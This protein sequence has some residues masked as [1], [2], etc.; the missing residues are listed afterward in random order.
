[1]GACTHTHKLET[2]G[3]SLVNMTE[4]K[5]SSKTGLIP[6][7]HFVNTPYFSK[8]LLTMPTNKN[9]LARY[10]IINRCLTSKTKKVWSGVELLEE[11]KKNDLKISLRQ[12]QTD[13]GIM[14]FDE[15]LKY[16]APIDTN[17]KGYF[18]TDSNYSIDKLNLTEKQLQSF[19]FVIKNLYEFKDLAIMHEFRGALEKVA[20]ILSN[21]KD[22]DRAAYVDFEKAPYY[23]GL[24]YR[25]ELV[26]ACQSK[27]ILTISYTTHDRTHP[28]KHTVDPYSIKEYKNWWYVVCLLHHK[29]R[30]II[31]ALDRINSISAS[32]QTYTP[33]TTFCPKEYFKD[34]LGITC[35]D[36]P[37]ENI[38]LQLTPSFA[39]YA[40]K[41]H[42][43]ASQTIVSEDKNG[44]VIEL[45]MKNNY[46]LKSTILSHGLGVTVLQPEG[47]RQEMKQIITEML[48]KY[49]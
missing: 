32:K 17:S 13:I 31:L 44:T 38:V 19:D 47:L 11:L 20:G 39:K 48:K 2:N 23:E 34:F 40:K 6:F 36:G 24:N 42:I 21:F 45:K 7:P 28:F 18:Y 16:N 4:G 27:T 49:D 10:I 12:L 46:E 14:R 5:K 15:R 3:T 33:S 35:T 43:H 8:K 41:Q 25:D 1:M 37:V 9:A 22:G 30:P 29:Q 26:D